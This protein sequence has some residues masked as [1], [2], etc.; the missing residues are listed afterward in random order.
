MGF[1]SDAKAA[2]DNYLAN[3]NTQQPSADGLPGGV[4]EVRS[5]LTGD[6][7]ERYKEGHYVDRSYLVT[8][9]NTDKDKYIKV[10]FHE[11]T[12]RPI[13]VRE[14]QDDGSY[15]SITSPQRVDD[16]FQRMKEA[17]NNYTI[18]SAPIDIFT[19][20]EIDE[21]SHDKADVLY[22][23]VAMGEFNPQ[24]VF[25]INNTG[26][27]RFGTRRSKAYN[28]VDGQNN[29]YSM[30][31]KEYMRTPASKGVLDYP[32]VDGFRTQSV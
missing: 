9:N 10:Y 24:E 25:A 17:S 12:G 30:I 29:I 20:D 8:D 11:E 2:I 14:Y 26:V 32:E 13:G 6:D 23:T 21:S 7:P 3:Q 19:P 1:F 22:D 5:V 28:T 18:T 4:Q 16:Y 15:I 27:R 31:L